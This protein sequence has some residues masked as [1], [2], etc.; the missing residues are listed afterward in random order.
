MWI[1]CNVR[2]LLKSILLL[3]SAVDRVVW[4]LTILRENV[5]FEER[6]MRQNRVVASRFTDH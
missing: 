5:A 2:W 6:G 3:S 1:C 4:Q